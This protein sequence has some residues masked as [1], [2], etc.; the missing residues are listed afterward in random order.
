MATGCTILDVI[1]AAHINPNRGD[2]DNH[3]SNGLLLRSDIHTLFDLDLMGIEPD[4]LRIAFRSDID[5]EYRPQV[6]E[7]LIIDVEHQPSQTALQMRYESYL[8]SIPF[9]QRMKLPRGFPPHQ[10]R[11]GG[12]AT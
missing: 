11:S 6:A 12:L 9:R 3:F 10:R 5:V 1:D 8:E 4:T 7:S 2:H